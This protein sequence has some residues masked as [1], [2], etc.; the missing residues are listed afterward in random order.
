MQL[1]GMRLAPEERQ[2]LCLRLCLYCGQSGHFVST[3]QLRLKGGTFSWSQVPHMQ[4]SAILYKYTK[5]YS[6]RALLDSEAEQN[7][8]NNGLL[9]HWY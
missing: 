6:T 4:L 2:R 3:Y 5:T 1:G 8:I 7:L 9:Q